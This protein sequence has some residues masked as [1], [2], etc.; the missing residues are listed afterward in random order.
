MKMEIIAPKV[1]AVQ[2]NRVANWSF[3]HLRLVILELGWKCSCKYE[4]RRVM[5]PDW[6]QQSCKWTLEFCVL[7]WLFV[8]L[9]FC[10][11]FLICKTDRSARW[12]PLWLVFVKC[13]DHSKSS[14]STNYC[15]SVFMRGSKQAVQLLLGR[16]KSR[17]P[18]E[19]SA[20]DRPYPGFGRVSGAQPAFCMV[21]PR[22]EVI[23]NSGDGGSL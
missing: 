15:S 8:W 7:L 1:H 9:P 23:V 17:K 5:W 3:L 11:S 19:C 20:Q 12:R 22:R 2:F 14:F 13:F 6:R 16:I 4:E 10:L 18:R 21:C